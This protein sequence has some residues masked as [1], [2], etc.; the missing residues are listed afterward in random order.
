MHVSA[1]GGCQPSH[2]QVP[3]TEQGFPSGAAAGASR[4]G[5]CAWGNTREPRLGAFPPG[6]LPTEPHWG[7]TGGEGPGA[8]QAL[9]QGLVLTTQTA[10]ATPSRARVTQ[11]GA[12]T[13]AG[14]QRST[15]TGT[16]ATGQPRYSAGEWHL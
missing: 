13:A 9:R 3:S 16:R 8:P 12:T 2:R 4:R 6:S 15:E 10:P 7:S 11:S 1:A 14:S 5:G